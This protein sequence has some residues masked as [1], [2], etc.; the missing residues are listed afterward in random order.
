MPAKHTS[1]TFIGAREEEDVGLRQTSLRFLQSFQSQNCLLRLGITRGCSQSSSQLYRL[2][3][4]G[5]QAFSTSS[6]TQ[7]FGEV[8]KH[9]SSAIQSTLGVAM[10]GSIC[11]AVGSGAWY[12]RLADIIVVF[13]RFLCINSWCCQPKGDLTVCMT[14]LSDGFCQTSTEGRAP[15]VYGRTLTLHNFLP[16]APKRLPWRERPSSQQIQL[17]SLSC[18]KCRDLSCLRGVDLRVGRQA[19]F[20]RHPFCDVGPHPA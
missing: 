14:S 16:E 13:M 12:G 2:R 4:C 7:R 19:L 20:N 6:R 1:I 18:N 17:L 5:G 15:S 10:V 9:V 8:K 3:D 11:T